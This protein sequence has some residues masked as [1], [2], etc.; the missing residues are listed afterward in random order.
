MGKCYI[1]E[2]EA[3]TRPYGE[4]HQEICF[5]CMT[6][7]EHPEREKLAQEIFSKQLLACGPVAELT[8]HGPVPASDKNKH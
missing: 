7:P 6:D 4:K 3:E 1:C 2:Q 5:S 8:E